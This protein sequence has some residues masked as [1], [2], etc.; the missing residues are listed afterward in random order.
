MTKSNTL[1][2]LDF[3]L[4]ASSTIAEE[5]DMEEQANE[6]IQEEEEEEEHEMEVQAIK[7]EEDDFMDDEDSIF[8]SDEGEDDEIMDDEEP[9]MEDEEEDEDAPPPFKY[10]ILISDKYHPEYGLEEL[11]PED[12]FLVDS[13]LAFEE[14]AIS[15]KELAVLIIESL[16]ER[17]FENGEHWEVDNGTAR[18]LEAD[19]GGGGDLEGCA[20][21]VKRQARLDWNDLYSVA[22]AKGTIII[23]A[24][25]EEIKVENYSYFVAG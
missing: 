1:D 20:F 8:D 2:S 6:A 5:P 14:G 19:E 4:D 9:E 16:F 3:L 17:D 11:Y 15:N 24:E 7:E 22:A 10:K 21:V 25:K 18:D 13:L 12:L 23:S